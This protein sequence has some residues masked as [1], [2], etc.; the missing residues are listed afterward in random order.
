MYYRKK[1]WNFAQPAFQNIIQIVK[2][3]SFFNGLKRRR[4]A[5]SWSKKTLYNT[6]RNDGDFYCLNC[7]QSFRTENKLKS[8]ERVCK[9]K[10]FCGI[11]ISFQK[12]NLLPFNQ[13][14][15]SVKMTCIVYAHIESFIKK[16]DG[17]AD[18]PQKSC[19][20]VSLH[21]L[22]VYNISIW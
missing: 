11:V 14:M 20:H 6:R 4:L 16:I 18:N 7:L 8:H 17:C 3:K 15:K 9:N 1:K 12:E 5:L 2:N 10:Y 13:Y 22:N 21:I 19:E